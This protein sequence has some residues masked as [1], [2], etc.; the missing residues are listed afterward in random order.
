MRVEVD[1]VRLYFDVT[2][3]GAV[4]D[5]MALGRR[6]TIVAL[7]GGPGFDHAYMRRGLAPLAQEFQIVFLDQRGQGQSG[8]APL[9]TCTIAQMADDTA[10]F[11][12]A[13]E[14]EAPILLGH[15][16]G[17][18]VALTMAVGGILPIGGLVLAN[19]AAAIRLGPALDGFERRYG[20][21]LRRVAEKVFA[22]DIDDRILGA[23]QTGVLPTYTH[24][25]TA[26][27][28]A[29]LA[30]CRLNPA[31]AVHFFRHHAA[32]YDVGA[33]LGRIDAPSLVVTGADDWIAP[34]EVAG[35]LAGKIP[36]A[37]LAVLPDTGH[38]SFGERPEAFAD[39]VRGFARRRLS[40]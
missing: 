7:H 15:S 18:Y 12:R 39:L 21:E 6:P 13:L 4:A 26:H 9:D 36:G 10:A 33:V 17:G 14:I 16:F 23:Y 1:G 5:G 31:F 32:R 8:S 22:G 27:A 3:P 24:P 25:S 35:E 2:G 34:A 29:D 30:L 28:L 37:E 20:A 40:A 19:T 38:F 11:C